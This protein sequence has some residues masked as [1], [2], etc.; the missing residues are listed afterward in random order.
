MSS[1]SPTNFPSMLANSFFSSNGSTGSPNHQ[2]RSPSA[3]SMSN[4]HGANKRYRTHLTP[5]QVYVMKALFN[6]YKTPSMTECDILG[7]EIGLNKRVVQVW[8]QNARAKERKCRSVTGDEDLPKTSN[9]NCSMCGIDF[10][11]RTPKL[12]MQDHI[13]TKRHISFLSERFNSRSTS[14]S[15]NPGRH[16]GSMSPPP[17]MIETVAAPERV[18]A[19]AVRDSG[20]R[21]ASSNNPRPAS[22]NSQFPFNL[23]YGLQS[24]TLPH[25]MCDPSIL[26]T[27]IAALQIPQ[28]VMQQIQIDIQAGKDSTKFTQDGLELKDLKAKISEDDF[29]CVTTVTNEVGYACPGCSY[30]FQ[31][32]QQLE[33]HQK[34]ICQNFEG[35][36]FKLLQIHYEC[37]A[38]NTKTGTQDDF[39]KHIESQT[40]QQI[41]NLFIQPV[42]ENFLTTS[43]M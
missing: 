1:V 42:I 10:N 11:S 5:L 6:D 4:Q 17:Q 33:A 23:M 2:Q 16:E 20:S 41:R 15:S 19:R 31:Q 25:L 39:K 27:P 8:F 30:T 12:T 28:A 35:K 24:G 36:I 13:F 29:K 22:T 32:Q 21:K 26:G 7:K 14:Q 18:R 43:A 40:H 38:C 9:E 3:T 37:I 34:I